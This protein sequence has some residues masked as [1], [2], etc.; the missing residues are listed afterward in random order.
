MCRIDCAIVRGSEFQEIKR[1]LTDGTELFE[2]TQK[3]SKEVLRT[4]AVA[5]HESIK[6]EMEL[7]GKTVQSLREEVRKAESH[8]EGV[9]LRMKELE[10]YQIQISELLNVLEP[11]IIPSEHQFDMTW[12]EQTYADSQVSRAKDMIYASS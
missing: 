4:S 12:N 1:C 11:Q 8:L 7:F 10:T 5:G 3:L 6:Q 2:Q 9:L